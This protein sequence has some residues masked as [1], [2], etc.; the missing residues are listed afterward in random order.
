MNSFWWKW[1]AG[2][3]AHTAPSVWSC[4]WR[5]WRRPKYCQWNL[6]ASLAI[7]Q[8]EWQFGV[9]DVP[10]HAQSNQHTNTLYTDSNATNII[11]IFGSRDNP[12]IVNIVALFIS[13]TFNV[14]G[15]WC[16]IIRTRN[17]F[18]TR[19]HQICSDFFLCY[20]FVLLFRFFFLTWPVLCVQLC[21]SC[22]FFD[23]FAFNCLIYASAHTTWSNTLWNIVGW[24]YVI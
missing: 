5:V 10:A 15:Q 7:S 2:A 20:C 21:C 18:H 16:K 6:H 17:K 14:D 12:I 22:S 23:G 1:R 19:R 24:L 11:I 8:F 3:R 4:S 9:T 13:F